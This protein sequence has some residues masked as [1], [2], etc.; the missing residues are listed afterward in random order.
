MTVVFTEDPQ[1][2][3]GIFNLME[4]IEQAGGHIMTTT[5]DTSE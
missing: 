3:D 1:Y 5:V 2:D 4:A